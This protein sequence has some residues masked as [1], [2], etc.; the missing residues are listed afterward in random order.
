MKV[1]LLFFK[2]DARIEFN[3]HG[4]YTLGDFFSKDK[5]D[6]KTAKF[7]KE[8]VPS[9]FTKTCITDEW[10][11]MTLDETQYQVIISN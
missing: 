4:R 10:V 7:L 3:W 9:L 5:E 8:I 6:V 11:G 2:T 1:E